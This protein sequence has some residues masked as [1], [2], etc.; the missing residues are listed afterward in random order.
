LDD[1]KWEIIII[2]RKLLFFGCFYDLILICFSFGKSEMSER[3]SRTERQTERERERERESRL[4]SG[5][6]VRGKGGGR[7]VA[8]V[9]L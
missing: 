9:S 7:G 4:K 8:F 5:V 2:N 6:V 3:N 1:E